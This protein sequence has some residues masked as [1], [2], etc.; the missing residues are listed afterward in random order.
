MSASLPYDLPEKFIYIFRNFEISD[1][2]MDN[3]SRLAYR[4]NLQQEYSQTICRNITGNGTIPIP[5]K[6]VVAFINHINA[7]PLS[8]FSATPKEITYILL[9]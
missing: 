5:N 2:A 9:S 1:C 8:N 6:L 4:E 7:L 3:T